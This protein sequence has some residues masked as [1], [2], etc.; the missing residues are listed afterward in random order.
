M[1]SPDWK[2]LPKEHNLAKFLADLPEILQSTGHDEMYGVHLE[3]ATETYGKGAT[4]GVQTI[5]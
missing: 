5:D 4:S 3:A 2:D 1:A